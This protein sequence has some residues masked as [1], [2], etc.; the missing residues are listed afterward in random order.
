MWT[1]SGGGATRCASLR[2]LA[3]RLPGRA[4]VPPGAVDYLSLMNRRLLCL[5]G[6]FYQPPREN[7]WIEE[8]EVQDTATPFHDW[9]ERIA[10]ECYGPNAAA[11]LKNGG[12]HIKDIVN[13][14][15]HISFN[16]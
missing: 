12:G 3:G 6:H 15:R 9:N 8:V 11:R 10:A 16:F 13:N 7:P 14:Y 2:A 4:L 5:H 1:E